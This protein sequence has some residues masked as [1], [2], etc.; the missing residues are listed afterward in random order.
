MNLFL[1]RVINTFVQVII[2]MILGRAIMSW[3]IR[4]GDRLYPLYMAIIRITEPILTPFR[5]LTSRYMGGGI[6]FSPMLA[7]VAIYF[8]QRILTKLLLLTTF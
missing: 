7:I 4:P 2:Y 1:I 6:D 3:F 8:I 5:N